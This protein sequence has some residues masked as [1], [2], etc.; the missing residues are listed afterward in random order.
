MGLPGVVFQ[1]KNLMAKKKPWD[2][3]KPVDSGDLDSTFA[4]ACSRGIDVDGL[5]QEGRKGLRVMQ[6]GARPFWRVSMSQKRWNKI[7]GKR[8]VTT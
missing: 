7:F 6:N 3:P 8:V 1:E 5:Q 2:K 4:D